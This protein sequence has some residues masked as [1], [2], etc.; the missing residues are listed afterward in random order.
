VAPSPGKTPESG[1]E[2]DPTDRIEH[3]I[4]APPMGQPLNVG[5]KRVAQ[6]LP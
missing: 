2:C 5:P 6:V 3:D 4:D 1:L